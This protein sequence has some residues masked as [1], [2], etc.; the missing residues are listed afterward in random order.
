MLRRTT[1][2][3]GWRKATIVTFLGVAA[4]ALSGCWGVYT[5]LPNNQYGHPY[6]VTVHQR[7]TDDW[8]HLC[9]DDPGTIGEARCV[10]DLVRWCLQ[11]GA[12]RMALG[13]VSRCDRALVHDLPHIPAGG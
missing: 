2:T 6:Y 4:L 13:R 7:P 1:F 8:I 5:G 11:P 9:D 3:R 10:L 12:D